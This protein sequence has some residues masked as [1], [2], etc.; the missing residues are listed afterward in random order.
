MENLNGMVQ[1]LAL[2]SGISV[3]VLILIQLLKKTATSFD[4]GSN[5]KYL[6][7]ISIA[8]GLAIGAIV[9]PFTDME[10]TLRLWAGFFAGA[11]ASGLYDLGKTTKQPKE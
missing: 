2:A 3:V 11:G 1:V 5:S 10:I 8:I 9:Y 6:P 4:K 7:L